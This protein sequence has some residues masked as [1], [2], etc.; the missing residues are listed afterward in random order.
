[1]KI[2]RLED[3]D[4]S[5]FSINDDNGES[6]YFLDKKHKK[7]FNGIVYGVFQSKLDYEVEIKNGYKNGIELSYSSDGYIEQIS[8][9]KHNLLYG[10]SKEYRED[11]SLATVSVVLNNN[12]LKVVEVDPNG[13]GIRV[14]QY[15]SELHKNIPE[16]I[17]YLLNLPEE[18][19]IAYPFKS[20]YN[21]LNNKTDES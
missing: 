19:L 5:L 13:N 14:V 8:E 16:D 17:L 9:C 1:M 12:H 10:V 15:Q 2:L 21:L 7:P 18:E 6:I 3:I 20:E 4:D 11:N